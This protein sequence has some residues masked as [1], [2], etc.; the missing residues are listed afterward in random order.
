MNERATVRDQRAKTN[1][2]FNDRKLKLGTF[3]TNLDYG[4]AI[5]RSTASSNQLAEHA[6]AGASS[7]RDAVEAIVPVGRWHGFGG[8]S[9]STAR[10][11]SPIPGRRHRRGDQL[12]HVFATSHLTTVHPIMAAKQGTTI[13]HVTGGRFALNI[14]TGWN[15]PEIEMFG[16]DMTEHDVRYDFAAEWLEIIKRLWTE[17]DEF[18]YEGKSTASRRAS[19]S[20]SRS[21]RRSRR[22]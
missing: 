3:G 20:R 8:N 14:V 7:R 6:E 15:R 18:D 4:C 22:S 1:P 12:F 11:S 2:L 5:P 19:C 9:I 10:A 16:L 13:D 17:D 21:R